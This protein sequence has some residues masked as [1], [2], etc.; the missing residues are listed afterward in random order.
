M[1]D[2]EPAIRIVR[3]NY[4]YAGGQPALRDVS[5][6]VSA[7]E[8]VALVGPGG[9]GKST[10]LLHLNGLLPTELPRQSIHA[11]VFVNG[12]G[13][14]RDSA[15]TIRKRIGLMFQ[16]PDDQL[17]SATVGDDVAFGPRN[18][19]LSRADIQARVTRTLDAVSLSGYEQ[20]SP[21]QLSLGER[22][23]VCLAGLLACEP[24]ILALDEPS[25]GLDPRARRQL[26][27]ILRRFPGAK[28]VAS[29]DLDFVAQV[30]ERV[31]VLDGGMI[32]ADGPVRD[33]LTNSSLMEQHG[34]EVPLR[35]KSRGEQSF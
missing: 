26:M 8:S 34:L 11:E 17:F 20:R 25:A 15:H 2:S 24:N 5:L 14:T 19:G 4:K 7:H 21:L 29:H 28:I 3:L 18:L 10:L 22:K 9:A 6:N 27:S 16:E 13:V 12:M 33:I 35:L 23:R 1:I 30:C 31:V 32:R